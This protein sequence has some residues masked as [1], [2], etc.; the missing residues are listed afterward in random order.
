MMK[1]LYLQGQLPDSLVSS[2]I[3]LVRSL[4]GGGLMAW[5]E[6]F[7]LV[8]HLDQEMDQSTRAG[9][10]DKLIKLLLSS[11]SSDGLVHV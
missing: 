11:S 3:E 8:D 9:T 6:V 7:S 1:R 5:K 4:R 2:S 10:K